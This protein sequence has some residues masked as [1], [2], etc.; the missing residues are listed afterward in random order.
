MFA[1]NA[2]QLY[3]SLAQPTMHG[4]YTSRIFCF[5]QVCLALSI[6]ELTAK[7][8]RE[9]LGHQQ[10]HALLL[11]YDVQIQVASSVVCFKS[12]APLSYR[13]RFGVST[14]YGSSRDIPPKRRVIYRAAARKK[15]TSTWGRGSNSCFVSN[16]ELQ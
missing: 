10:Q 15:E 11:A 7:R 9:L 8:E 4:A 1:R 2:Q 16:P 5:T 3:T 14:A 13:A 12:T 6:D